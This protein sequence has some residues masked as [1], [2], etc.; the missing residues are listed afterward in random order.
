MNVNHPTINNGQSYSVTLVV[1]DGSLTDS[2]TFNLVVSDS[3]YANTAPEFNTPCPDTTVTFGEDFSLQLDI[4]DDSGAVITAVTYN[5]G[6]T[7]S[8]ISFSGDTLAI[9]P[10]SGHIGFSVEI[11]V[12]I[13]D[14]D[15]LFPL[16]STCS[17]TLF[18]LAAANACPVFTNPNL[19]D[20]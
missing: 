5:N 15:P 11:E 6:N 20:I 3:S 7:V 12:T 16:S 18:T 13:T 10:L 8:S 19:P 4:V 14:D 17:L 9:T 1:T 2:C